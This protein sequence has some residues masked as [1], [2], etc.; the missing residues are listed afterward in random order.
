M[1]NA[2]HTQRELYLASLRIDT[3]PNGVTSAISSLQHQN[4]LSPLSSQINQSS[5]FIVQEQFGVVNVVDLLNELSKMQKGL[6]KHL[7][8]F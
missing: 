4:G 6:F 7:F 1:S 3:G 2:H 8:S 5:N